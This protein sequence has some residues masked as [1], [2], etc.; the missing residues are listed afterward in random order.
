MRRIEDPKKYYISLRHSRLLM[1]NAYNV[2]NWN[3]LL[4]FAV[5]VIFSLGYQCAGAVR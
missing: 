4:L 3:D 1:E 2:G 5:C